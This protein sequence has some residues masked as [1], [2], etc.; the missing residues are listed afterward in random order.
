MLTNETK[1]S[2]LINVLIVIINGTLVYLQA[3][4]R[5]KS[6]QQDDI[7]GA[8]QKI[9][10]AGDATFDTLVKRI[11]WLEQQGK[12]IPAL[13]CEIAEWK[14]KYETSE[15][16]NAALIVRVAELEAKIK[17]LENGGAK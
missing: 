16:K 3:R 5:P 17:V 2:W 11:E 9:V 4:A 1:I 7:S 8:A 6:Q 13:E 15:T 10:N 14:E 12:G